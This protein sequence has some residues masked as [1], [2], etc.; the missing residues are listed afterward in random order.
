MTDHL[1]THPITHYTNLQDELAAHQITTRS[2]PSLDRGCKMSSVAADY[3]D[4]CDN[5][6]DLGHGDGAPGSNGPDS[7]GKT[8]IDDFDGGEG[9]EW[10][11]QGCRGTLLNFHPDV[12]AILRSIAPIRQCR[13]QNPTEKLTEHH[14]PM[15]NPCM[16]ATYA[17]TDSQHAVA[18]T[19]AANDV[20]MA[21]QAQQ[22]AEVEVRSFSLHQT[23]VHPRSSL[24]CPTPSI[25][26]SSYLTLISNIIIIVIVIVIVTQGLRRDL[27]A[28]VA[29]QGQQSEVIAVN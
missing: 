23:S 4:C 14:A 13:E 21:A 19:V 11:C 7:Q 1:N 20:A 10:L 12:I 15:R 27:D 22:M 6:G 25:Y 2:D 9:K 16:H 29:A 3:E 28:A 5:N 8:D 24:L 18:T 26:L 17:R